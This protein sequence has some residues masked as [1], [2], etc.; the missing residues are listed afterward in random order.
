MLTIANVRRECPGARKSNE[1]REQ[2]GDRRRRN[3]GRGAGSWRRGGRGL[4]AVVLHKSDL[5]AFVI[6]MAWEERGGHRYYYQSERDEDGKVRK[7][8]IGT[9]EIAELVAHA[10]ETRR[11]AQA[12]RRAKEREELERMEALATSVLALDEAVTILARAHLVAAGYHRY[13]GEWRR[14]R[15]T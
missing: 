14:G 9:K 8:Y 15:N 6:A 7:K 11:Q 12:A 3:R 13:K 5:P 4:S 1:R 10:D 2:C